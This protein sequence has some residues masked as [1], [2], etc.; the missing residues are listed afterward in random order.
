VR[1]MDHQML[2]QAKRHFQPSGIASFSYGWTT[3]RGDIAGG[4]VA[5][6]LIVPAA[7]ASGS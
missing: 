4:L 5:S 2:M 1:G 6:A 3:L 7:R